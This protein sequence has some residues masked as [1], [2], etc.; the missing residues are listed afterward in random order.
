MRK[1]FGLRSSQAREKIYELLSACDDYLSA[2]DIFM[3]L[4]DTGIGIA[5]IYRNIELMLQRDLVT[6]IAVDGVSKYKLKVSSHQH[7]L[8]C[9][10]CGKILDIQDDCIDKMKEVVF[11]FT[12]YLE[13]KY[14]FSI[15]EHSV[16]F[17]G[18][19]NDCKKKELKI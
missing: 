19:C 1:K 14:N 16:D 4:R 10:N 5:T 12:Q 17:F 7:H 18:L 2:N 3:R 9:K 6:R 15:S 8:I 11:N 13:E